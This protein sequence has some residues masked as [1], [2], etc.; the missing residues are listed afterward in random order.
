MLHGMIGMP[1][2][3][4]GT[5]V[6]TPIKRHPQNTV[7]RQEL[8]KRRVVSTMQG[9]SMKDHSHSLWRSLWLG[10]PGME[11]HVILHFEFLDS[12]T[13]HA[14]AISIRNTFVA[15]D[16]FDIRSLPVEKTRD[17]V[18]SGAIAQSI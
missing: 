12:I 14:N 10:D 3:T 2:F 8:D 6:T 1:P 15:C 18:S 7:E 5:A 11:Q 13:F 16:N 17:Y 9:R 4:A